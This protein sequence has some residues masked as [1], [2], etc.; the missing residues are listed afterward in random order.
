MHEAEDMIM[1]DAG[2]IPVVTTGKAYLIH[3]G[4]TNYQLMP[5]ENLSMAGEIKKE[6]E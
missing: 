3:K 1:E 6:V 2:V 4:I 5:M